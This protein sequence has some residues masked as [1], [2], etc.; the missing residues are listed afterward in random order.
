VLDDPSRPTIVTLTVVVCPAASE[1][2]LRLMVRSSGSGLWMVMP[3]TGPPA[4]ASCLT[5]S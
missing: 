2:V 4:L 5:V 1:P 3:E